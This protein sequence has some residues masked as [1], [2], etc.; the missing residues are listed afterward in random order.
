MVDAFVF[1]RGHG[2]MPCGKGVLGMVAREGGKAA[3]VERREKGKGQVLPCVLAFHRPR[4]GEG[5]S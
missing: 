3:N 1:G 5:I 2:C 4:T